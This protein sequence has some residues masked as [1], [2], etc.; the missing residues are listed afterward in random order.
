MTMKQEA[1]RRAQWLKRLKKLQAERRKLNV[2][3]LRQRGHGKAHE[4][5]SRGK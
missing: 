1:Q 5:K 3:M 4:M 2:A